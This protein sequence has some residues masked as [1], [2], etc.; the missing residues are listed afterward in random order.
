MASSEVNLRQSV[1]DARIHSMYSNSV[2]TLVDPPVG[3]K[4]IEYKW[5]YKKNRGSN[6]YVKTFKARLVAKGYT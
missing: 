2:W 3:I 1:M 4:A 5:I 6:M